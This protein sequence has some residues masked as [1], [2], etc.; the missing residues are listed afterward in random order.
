VARLR[1]V[2]GGRA[3]EAS[4][5]AAEGGSASAVLV[6]IYPDDQD[7]LH[8]VLTRRATTLRT[9]QGEV[10]FPGGRAEP[11]EDPVT[12]ALREAS[13]EV[14]LDP[15]DVEPIGELDHLSTVTRRA[16]IVPVIAVLRGKPELVPS[17]AEVAAVLHVPLAEL[18]SGE[19]YR[20]E[21]WGRPPEDRGLHFFELHGD[22]V[23]GATAAM[24][25]HF[26]VL[27]LG[28]DPGPRINWDPAGGSSVWM[29]P[30]GYEDRVV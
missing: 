23:W 2:F 19:V 6:P 11:G 25:R 15:N 7:R 26:L 27:S 4:P 5:V 28:L 9:H 14:T 16:Y 30:P 21:R 13:E 22:T 29:P 18:L 3:G 10:S 8:V 20:E 17:E 1:T 12:T 24:L